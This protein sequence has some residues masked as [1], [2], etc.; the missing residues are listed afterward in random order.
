MRDGGTQHEGDGDAHDFRDSQAHWALASRCVQAR[1]EGDSEPAG[2]KRPH[3]DE[4]PSRSFTNVVTLAAKDHEGAKAD[5]VQDRRRRDLH[6]VAAVN[7]MSSES[8]NAAAIRAD[9]WRHGYVPTAGSERVDCA[10]T[11][12]EKH[13]DHPAGISTAT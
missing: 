5:A 3:D 7:H 9:E 13:D 4:E 10:C 6:G 12:V 8:A 2:N 1:H 11:G